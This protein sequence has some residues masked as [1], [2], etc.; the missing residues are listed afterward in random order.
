MEDNKFIAWMEERLEEKS[1]NVEPEDLAVM[2]SM[3]A[4]CSYNYSNEDRQE[5]TKEEQRS[6]NAATVVYLLGM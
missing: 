3:L 6:L 5:Y 4:K 2:T 1:S